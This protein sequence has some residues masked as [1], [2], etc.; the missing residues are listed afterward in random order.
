M[1]TNELKKI[2]KDLD[3]KIHAAIGGGWWLT[4]LDDTDIWADDNFC[5]TRG[6]IEEKLDRYKAELS[7]LQGA[8]E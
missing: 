4:K 1:T 2:A 6:E 5:A 3:V 8:R 7:W